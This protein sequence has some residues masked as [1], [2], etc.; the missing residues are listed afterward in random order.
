MG[1]L[2]IHHF[3][4][5]I[6]AVFEIIDL[7]PVANSSIAK[8]DRSDHHQDCQTNVTGSESSRGFRNF[9][10]PDGHQSYHHRNERQ[11][12]NQVTPVNRGDSG[13]HDKTVYG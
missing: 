9:L 10:P 1:G 3:F 6:K 12:I 4:K 7:P 13:I 5:R 8:S 11:Q 2:H